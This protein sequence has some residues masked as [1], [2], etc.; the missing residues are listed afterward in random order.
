MERR[1]GMLLARRGSDPTFLL[2]RL[3]LNILVVHF[4]DQFF[5]VVNFLDD[6]FQVVRYHEMLLSVG[7]LPWD[8]QLVRYHL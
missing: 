8:F 1:S 2:W 3:E 6:V 4:L 7:P 5:L